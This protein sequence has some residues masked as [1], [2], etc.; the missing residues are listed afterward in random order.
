[1][2]LTITP[3]VGIPLPFNVTPEEVKEFRERAKTAF[4]TVK[5]LIDS[6]AEV[7]DMDEKT[8]VQAHELFA[9][10]KPIAIAKTPSCSGVKVRGVVKSV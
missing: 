5:K 3:E 10:E 1:M 7:P 9:K 8:S 4:N 6:G 2:P